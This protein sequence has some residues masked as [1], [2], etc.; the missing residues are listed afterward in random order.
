MEK[1]KAAKANSV[2]FLDNVWALIVKV[3]QVVAGVKLF[4]CG[5]VQTVFGSVPIAA[6][7]GAVLIGDAVLFVFRLLTAQNQ[8]AKKK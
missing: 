6:I 5:N 2:L 7:F 1:I 4:D 8:P 3:A